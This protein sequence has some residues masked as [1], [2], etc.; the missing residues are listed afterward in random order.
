MCSAKRWERG[1]PR[2]TAGTEDH[3]ARAGTK[4][5]TKRDTPSATKGTTSLA[6]D[7][8]R[9]LMAV[10]VVDMDSGGGVNSKAVLWLSGSRTRT[11]N[12][13]RIKFIRMPDGRVRHNVRRSDDYH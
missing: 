10:T 2:P 9:H 5:A 7:T 6:D 12:E 4:L 11:T 3:A 8:R 13:I 1:S